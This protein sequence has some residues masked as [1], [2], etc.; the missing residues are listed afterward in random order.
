MKSESFILFCL[1]K[2]LDKLIYMYGTWFSLGT[3]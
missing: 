1:M 2:M 3:Q